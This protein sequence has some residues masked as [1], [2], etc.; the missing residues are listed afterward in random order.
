MTTSKKNPSKTM[1]LAC[2]VI[3]DFPYFGKFEG[4]RGWK[5]AE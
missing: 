3:F 5:P 2:E 1:K 4:S